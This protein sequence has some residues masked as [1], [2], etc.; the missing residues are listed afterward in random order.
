MKG[1]SFALQNVGVCNDRPFSMSWVSALDPVGFEGFFGED[2]VEVQLFF[3][4]ALLA[5]VKPADAA[6]MAAAV[7][8][9]IAMAAAGTSRRRFAR[10]ASIR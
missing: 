7:G 10:C 9:S 1:R 5:G 2:A 8:L 6:T 4:E 3:E